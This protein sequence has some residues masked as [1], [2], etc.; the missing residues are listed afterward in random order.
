MTKIKEE[1]FEKVVKHKVR[2]GDSSFFVWMVAI[3]SFLVGSIFT[4]VLLGSMW[5]TI[6]SGGCLCVAIIVGTT[7]DKKRIVYWRKIK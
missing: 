3:T 4:G 1:R 6:I 2:D 7:F 5:V